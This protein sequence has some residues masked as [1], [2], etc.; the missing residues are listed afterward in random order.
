MTLD[1]KTIC[2]LSI[3]KIVV[4]ANNITT[5][6]NYKENKQINKQG[7][8]RSEFS[9]PVQNCQGYEQRYEHNEFSSPM[10]NCLLKIISGR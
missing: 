4:R 3:N 8:E 6:N 1:V 10:Q 7:Y 2:N 9:S 5:A